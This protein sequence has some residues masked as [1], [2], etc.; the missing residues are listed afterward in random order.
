MTTQE[1]PILHQTRVVGPNATPD[2]WLLMLHG[3]Y[4]SGRNWG[5]I[6]RRLVEA[7]PEWGVLLVDLRNHGQSQGFTGPHTLMAS[8]GD[9]DR[10]VEHLDFHAAAV[11][12][13]SFGGKVALVYAQHHGQGLRQVWVMDSTLAV[14]EP[15]GSAWRIIDSMRAL[16]PTFP[17]RTEAV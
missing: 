16:P 6:A 5:T 14:R 10:L 17:S 2:R 3:I 7:R 4:G 9:L 11:M 15:E 12:G 13:H 8:A 1:Q